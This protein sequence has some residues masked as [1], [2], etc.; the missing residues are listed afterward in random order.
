MLFLAC[1]DVELNPSKSMFVQIGPRTDHVLGLYR[2]VDGVANV[3]VP[4]PEVTGACSYRYLGILF[5]PDGGWHAMGAAVMG[6]VRNWCT[7]VTKAR[8]PVDQA[9]M[10]LRSV[11]HGLLNYVLSAAP[12]KST[13]MER[14]DKLV[15]ASLFSCAGLPRGR[16]TAWA[17]VSL[18]QGGLGALSAT[19]LRRMV[20]LETVLARLNAA[21][22][23][24]PL[25]G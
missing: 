4:L 7:Q 16:R 5:Q 15:A 14:I 24:S 12:L 21:A 9:A 18:E 3:F 11:V 17:F 8:L 19:S 23:L 10:V 6:K 13:V 2:Y 25:Y 20:V 22:S 1:F